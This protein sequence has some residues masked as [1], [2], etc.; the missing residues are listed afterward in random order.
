MDTDD[1]HYKGQIVGGQITGD[2][3]MFFKNG[4][5]YDGYWLDGALNGKGKYV[6]ANGDT[7]T[8]SFKLGKRSG[9][10][11]HIK[12]ADSRTDLGDG[13]WFYMYEGGY[14]D[15][16]RWGYGVLKELRGPGE[17]EGERYIEYSG[18][19]EDNT[20]HGKGHMLVYESKLKQIKFEDHDGAFRDGVKDGLGRNL[21]LKESDMYGD[22]DEFR[23]EVL[24]SSTLEYMDFIGDFIND[25]PIYHSGVLKTVKVVTPQRDNTES[26]KAL[27]YGKVSPYLKMLATQK[28]Q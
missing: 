6:Y 22:E 8:G 23:K 1:G 16:L 3:I 28:P 25:H 18:D 24:N 12:L 7:F 2:G 19:W 26:Y 5:K 21:K 17:V 15:D 4:D 9:K 27:E 20:F 14:E 13:T 11:L 10:G